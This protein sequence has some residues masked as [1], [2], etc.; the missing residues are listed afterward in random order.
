MDSAGN[1]SDESFKVNLRLK[2]P[3][4]QMLGPASL[5]EKEQQ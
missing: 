1:A 4:K 5:H 2:G 3:R